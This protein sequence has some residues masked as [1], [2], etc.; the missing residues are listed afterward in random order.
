MLKL[1]SCIDLVA[2]EAIYIIERVTLILNYFPHQ[3]NH[4]SSPII[5][6][7]L[8]Y[9]DLLY[10][11]WAHLY[12]PPPLGIFVDHILFNLIMYNV[13]LRWSADFL[14][15]EKVTNG[16]RSIVPLSLRVV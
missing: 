4:P 2:A 1:N 13:T 10:R 6:Y 14:C 16:H 3:K 7:N 12:P 15:M 9:N 5:L 11:P 8:F